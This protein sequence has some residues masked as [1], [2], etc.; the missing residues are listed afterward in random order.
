MD[1]I[2]DKLNSIIDK[3]NNDLHHLSLEY[4][5][6]NNRTTTCGPHQK[7]ARNAFRAL[8]R[9]GSAAIGI[10][11]RKKVDR[12]V[13]DDDRVST[14]RAIDALLDQVLALANEVRELNRTASS[15]ERRVEGLCHNVEGIDLELGRMKQ[16]I[17]SKASLNDVTAGLESTRRGSALSINAALS[18][19]QAQL[20]IDIVAAMNEVNDVRAM[21]Q[22]QISDHLDTISNTTQAFQKN[23]MET[24]KMVVK[25]EAK[26]GILRAEKE[27]VIMIS[28]TIAKAVT[29]I[30]SNLSKDLDDRIDKAIK[31]KMKVLLQHENELIANKIKE[32]ITV[33]LLPMQELLEQTAVKQGHCMAGKK[34]KS[35]IKSCH[36]R[37]TQSMAELEERLSSSISKKDLM[38]RSLMNQQDMMRNSLGTFVNKNE[39]STIAEDKSREA[40]DRFAT[41]MKDLDQTKASRMQTQLQSFVIRDE[42]NA[43]TNQ[44]QRCIKRIEQLESYGDLYSSLASRIN[45]ITEQLGNAVTRDDVDS[46]GKNLR[47]NI[48]REMDDF[49][50]QMFRYR[51]HE[52]LLT[53]IES[54]LNGIESDLHMSKEFAT[55]FSNT[56]ST[57]LML[58]VEDHPIRVIEVPKSPDLPHDSTFVPANNPVSSKDDAEV[59]QQD[60]LLQERNTVLNSVARTLSEVAAKR[61][62]ASLLQ[63]ANAGCRSSSRQSLDVQPR[64]S[65]TKE[66]DRSSCTDDDVISRISTDDVL[67]LSGVLHDGEEGNNCE[68]KSDEIELHTPINKANYAEDEATLPGSVTSFDE[69]VDFKRNSSPVGCNTGSWDSLLTEL[70]NSGL[71]MKDC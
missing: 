70:K 45:I 12:P 21:L 34:T 41:V 29:E 50:S 19:L 57:P 68:R 42:L 22:K 28:Q 6:Q 15:N 36:L 67:S 27:C 26:A 48:M 55:R 59:K 51:G 53:R 18:P 60:L 63:L 31:E 69:E 30:E 14:S 44:Y 39:V 20:K 4:N 10:T 56:T 2:D 17:T 16:D 46:K 23:L 52:K 61:D 35:L 66:D 49:K 25:E 58:Q 43:I 9:T 37:L 24:M 32:T 8:T 40:V 47:Q 38:L 64:Y 13:V 7:A 62:D 33:D 1:N 5:S 71:I 65:E 54:R 3:T 11:N